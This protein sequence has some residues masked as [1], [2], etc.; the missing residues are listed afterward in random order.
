MKIDV[1]RNQLYAS[2]VGN[3]P[4][5]LGL[6]FI[7][8]VYSLNVYMSGNL[9]A[10]TSGKKNAIWQQEAIAFA[11]QV[12]VKVIQDVNVEDGLFNQVVGWNAYGHKMVKSA[13]GREVDGK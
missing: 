11:E 10:G 12:A 3:L 6:G 5:D 8:K 13:F 2:T 9:E 4:G 7:G 1:I